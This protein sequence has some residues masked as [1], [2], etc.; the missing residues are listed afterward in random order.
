MHEPPSLNQSVPQGTQRKIFD[1]FIDR[2]PVTIAL[3]I[4]RLTAQHYTT[5]T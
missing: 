5:T 4:W 1:N 3:Q 2:V